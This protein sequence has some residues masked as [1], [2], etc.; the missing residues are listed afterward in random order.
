MCTH[1]NK[2]ASGVLILDEWLLLKNTAAGICS[3]NSSTLILLKAF[4][5]NLFHKICEEAH[6]VEKAAF[7]AGV[8]LPAQARPLTVPAT[9]I[10]QGWDYTSPGG[11]PG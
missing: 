8:F 9:A 11:F 6:T 10:R 1:R 2:P 3:L 5:H 4:A 7:V